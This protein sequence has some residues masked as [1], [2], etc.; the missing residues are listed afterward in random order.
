MVKMYCIEY[1][2][3]NGIRDWLANWFF[4]ERAARRFAKRHV[5][6]IGTRY[7]IRGM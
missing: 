4:S 3:K 7:T 5:A 2:D 1:I 6:E